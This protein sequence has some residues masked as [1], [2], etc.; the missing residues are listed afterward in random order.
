MTDTN[1]DHAKDQDKDKQQDQTNKNKP[2]D[3]LPPRD[4]H[5]P[6]GGTPNKPA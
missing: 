6:G 1:K 3:K 4:Q 2:N 5:L